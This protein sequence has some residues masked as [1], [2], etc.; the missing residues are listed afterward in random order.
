MLNFNESY[1]KDLYKKNNPQ[2]IKNAD[3]ESEKLIVAKAMSVGKKASSNAAIIAVF[4]CLVISL[5]KKY[6]SNILAIEKIMG[7]TIVANS[8]VPKI[9]KEKAVNAIKFILN[10]VCG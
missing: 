4:S 8:L 1:L 2:L 5:T 10:G 6:A 9:E 3:G 7:K